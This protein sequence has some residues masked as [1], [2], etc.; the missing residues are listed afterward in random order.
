[1]AD[2]SEVSSKVNWQEIDPNVFE[3]PGSYEIK[4]ITEYDDEVS[5]KLTVVEEISSLLN[6]STSTIVGVKP[7]SYTH[8]RAHET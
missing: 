7:V 3:T 4:G 8:L 5:V 2:G 6:H 1:M